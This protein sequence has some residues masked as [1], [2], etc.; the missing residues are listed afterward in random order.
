MGLRGMRQRKFRRPM[1]CA[2]LKTQNQSDTPSQPDLVHACKTKL[3]HAVTTPK[4]ILNW[5]VIHL[6]HPLVH[7]FKPAGFCEVQKWRG[8]RRTQPKSGFDP[9]QPHHQR[10]S[11]RVGAHVGDAKSLEAIVKILKPKAQ[12]VFGANVR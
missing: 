10:G 7:F 4:V 3:G 2:A 9:R 6:G 8:L 11:R 5:D 1:S 12:T